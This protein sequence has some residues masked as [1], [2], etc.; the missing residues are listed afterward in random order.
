MNGLRDAGATTRRA[1]WFYGDLVITHVSGE[2]TEGRFC[3]LEFLQPPGEWTPLHVRRNADL[4]Q[5]VLE[6]ELT[7]HIPDRSFA[8]G[9]GNCLNVP[10]K[11]PRTECV[12]STG[13]VRVLDFTAPAGFDAMVAEAG[14]PALE[15]ELPPPERPAPDL[16]RLAAVAADH[17]IDILGPPGSLP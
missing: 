13:P 14:E 15:L 8:L 5:Y 3:L 7:V 10:M 1:H 2:E 11:V 16:E 17:G 9:P 4:T 12:T 6:G